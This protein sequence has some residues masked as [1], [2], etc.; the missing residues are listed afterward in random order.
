MALLPLNALRSIGQYNSSDYFAILGLPVNANTL[1]IR[2]R[3]L[4]IVRNLHP[5]IYGRTVEEKHK[6]CEY[7]AKLVSPAYNMLMFERERAE[8][9]ALLKLIAKR[10]MKREL[11]IAPKSEFARKLLHSPSEP[12]YLH[13][14]E[15]IAKLQYQSLD[16]ILEY[17]DQLGELNL[18]YSMYQEGYHPSLFE[19]GQDVSCTLNLPA[20]PTLPRLPPPQTVRNNQASPASQLRGSQAQLANR[21]QSYLRLVEDY[22]N[23]NPSGASDCVSDRLPNYLQLAECYISQKQWMMAWGVLH[24][25]LQLDPTN[26][27]CHA[28][29]GIVYLNQDLVGMAK[30]SF[31]QA[32]KINP[33]EPLAL[34][35]IVRCLI[36]RR[37]TFYE[38]IRGN[39]FFGWLGGSQVNDRH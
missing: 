4:N 26:S 2:Q 36:P 23:E 15:A 13:S 19:P 33:R 35:H 18:I 1:Q 12:H 9:L 29:L 31:Q 20:L 5:D 6:A 38:Y 21:V 17:T 37:N 7:L 25:A 14:V 27:K 30:I 39:G 28:L 11:K 10:L 16:H 32:L 22:F 24:T 3:Y 8:Y 34:K